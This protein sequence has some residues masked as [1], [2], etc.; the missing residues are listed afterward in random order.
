MEKLAKNITQIGF[1]E[2]F[3]PIRKLGKGGFATVY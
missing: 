2:Q 3:R 1:H